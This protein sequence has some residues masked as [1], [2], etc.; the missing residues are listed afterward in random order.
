MLER[1]SGIY[2]WDINGK[3]YIA[4]SSGPLCVNI[5]YGVEEITEAIIEQMKKIAFVHDLAFT[6]EPMEKLADKI[7]EMAPGSLERIFFCSGGSE[8]T[9]S[10]IKMARQYS[11]EKG[12]SSK[13]KVISRWMSYHGNT[14]GALSVSGHILRRKKYLPLLLDF[15]HIPPAYCYRCW[16]GKEYPSC[17]LDCAWTLEKAIKTLGCEHVSA[18]IAEPIVGAAL[19]TVPAP[20]DYFKVVREICDKY[21]VLLIVDEVMT[22]FGRTGKNF[23]IQHY[24]VVP[25]IMVCSKGISGGYT[26]LGAVVAT[27]EIYE[28]F[29]ETPF[30]HGFTFGGNPVSCA[31][32]LAVL[33]YIS[34][35]NLVS[36]SEVMGKRLFEKLRRLYD[37]STVGDIR[38]K[39]LFAGIEFVK[40]RDTRKIFDADIDFRGKVLEKCLEMGLLVYSGTPVIEGFLGDTIQVAPPLIAREEQIDEIVKILD[41]SVGDVETKVVASHT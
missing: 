31:V 37:H 22:G 33:E 13:Y 18:F 38:G 34:N 20:N 12:K 16:F 15:T 6:S 23:G 32:C 25:D 8:A 30:Q 14:L 39:G 36:R 29:K 2:V 3:K 5:G 35:N 17:D 10:A 26:P 19:G 27:A 11:V 4:G 9:E 40:D 28:A 21:D 1:G 41:R 7:A 24:G